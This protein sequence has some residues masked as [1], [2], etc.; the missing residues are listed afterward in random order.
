MKTGLKIYMSPEV[1]TVFIKLERVFCLSDGG[2]KNALRGWN[3]SNTNAWDNGS[4]N[5][6]D[7][8]GGWTDNGGT[9]W[10]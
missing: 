8:L 4:S 3:P 7:D 9:A 1:G 10:Y 6:A 2:Q 5:E